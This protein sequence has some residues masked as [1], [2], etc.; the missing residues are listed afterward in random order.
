MWMIIVNVNNIMHLFY[1]NRIQIWWIKFKPN[2]VIWI[3]YKCRNQTMTFVYH[4]VESTVLNE[5]ITEIITHFHFINE[6]KSCP[7][8]TKY[9]WLWKLTIPHIDVSFNRLSCVTQFDYGAFRLRILNGIIE[10]YRHGVKMSWTSTIRQATI[11]NNQIRYNRY[12]LI[13]RYHIKQYTFTIYPNKGEANI[14]FMRPCFISYTNLI[15]RWA[16]KLCT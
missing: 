6:I 9:F 14:T 16:H 7:I 5:S 15:C 1:L 12:T 4:C 2:L 8:P 3:T 13:H 11:L 10:F